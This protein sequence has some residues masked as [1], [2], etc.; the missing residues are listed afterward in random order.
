MGWFRVTSDR[1]TYRGRLGK[2]PFAAWARTAEGLSTI[3]ERARRDRL[4]VFARARAH[5]RIWRELDRAG[6]TSAVA[7]AIQAEAD[8]FITLLVE[9]SHAPGLP[10]RTIA[11]HRLVVVPRA[12]AA[13]RARNAA[14]QRLDHSPPLERLDA[15]VRTFFFEQ[16]VVELDAAL[17]A[18]RPSPSRPVLTHDGWRC[19]GRDTDYQWVDPIFTG[20]GWGGHILMFEFPRE[21]L[22]RSARKEL[23]RAVHE[24]QDSLNGLPRP[25]RHD[26]VRM[27]VEEL[28]RLTGS[29]PGIA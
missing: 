18:R 7:A 8:R 11:L 13:A 15:R 22:S 17:A 19:V 9:A 23:D 25:Q 24:L 4:W 10:R 5:G 20:P 21:G 6:R 26:I 3:D 29:Q 2:E 27:A 12:L 1:L 28:P 14:R 16:L